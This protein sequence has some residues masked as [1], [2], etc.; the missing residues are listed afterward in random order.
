VLTGKWNVEFIE[1]GPELPEAYS[2]DSLCCWTNAPDEKAKFKLVY[3]KR[4]ILLKSELKSSPVLK[5]H[6]S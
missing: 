2:T 3:P 4:A 5:S 1:G 6:V